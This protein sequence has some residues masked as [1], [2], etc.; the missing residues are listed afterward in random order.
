[1]RALIFAVAALVWLPSGAQAA[2]GAGVGPSESWSEMEQLEYYIGQLSGIL[3]ICSHFSLSTDL[4]ELANLSPYGKKGLASVG[5]YD[6][7]KGGYCGKL[8]ADGE[9]LMADRDK[10]LAYL[11]EKYDCP[12]GTCAP[13]DGDTSLTAACRAEA[14]VHLMSLPVGTDDI[15]SVSMRR[16]SFASSQMSSGRW[17]SEAWVRLKSCSGWL[18][19]EMTDG[20]TVRQSFTR[21]DCEIE[22]I[23]G[24]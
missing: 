16:G 13:E 10:L 3:N 23:K 22:G 15:K 9:A 2:A 4:R 12:G 8:A 17:G 14:D 5:A 18:I 7:V 20:C 1:M 19:V 6:A 21:G 11:T 24:Y